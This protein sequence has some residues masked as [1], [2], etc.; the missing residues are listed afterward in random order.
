MKKIKRFLNN[1]LSYTTVSVIRLAFF[2]NNAQ[3]TGGIK[4]NKKMV[5]IPPARSKI[6]K[7]SKVFYE[8]GGVHYKKIQRML[9]IGALRAKKRF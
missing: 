6:Y 3:K 2:V 9:K 1:S 4:F 5:R 8:L 7:K